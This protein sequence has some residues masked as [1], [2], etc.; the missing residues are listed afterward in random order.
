MTSF[1][2]RSHAHKASLIH[3]LYYALCWDIL[4]LFLRLNN[5]QQLTRGSYTLHAAQMLFFSWLFE[6]SVDP[7]ASLNKHEAVSTF[8]C[9]IW[10]LMHVL[11]A[12]LWR[13]IDRKICAN[14]RA[15]VV[16]CTQ[17]PKNT[18]AVEPSGNLSTFPCWLK[19]G[20]HMCDF[21]GTN[22]CH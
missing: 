16:K 7:C 22:C 2:A 3:M 8:R 17:L 18:T 1:G 21:R 20:S 14:Q 13:H 5:R 12:F 15:L 19:F 9:C 6:Y 4:Q 11:K 10:R